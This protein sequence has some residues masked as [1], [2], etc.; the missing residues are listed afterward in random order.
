MTHVPAP[1]FAHTLGP[2]DATLVLVGEAWGSTEDQLK[3]PLVGWSGLELAR[4]LHETGHV[5]EPPP[6][7]MGSSVD[8]LRL[9]K[10]WKDSGILT[11]NVFAFRPPNNN[12]LHESICG[13]KAEVGG[14]DY[15]LPQLKVGKYVR[16]EYLGE[17]SRLYEELAAYPRN[18]IVAMG[19]TATWAL[20][21]DTRIGAIRG[22]I[23]HSRLSEIVS[24]WKILP[25]YHPANVLYQWSNRVILVVDLLKAKRERDFPDVRRPQRWIIVDPTLDEVRQWTARTLSVVKDWKHGL[26]PRCELLSVD[27]ETF[28]GQI[29]SIA[30]A[31]SRSEAL[32]VPFV[33]RRRPG[34]SY[35][36]TQEVEFEVWKNVRALCESNI[37]KLFQNGLFDLTYLYRAGIRPRNCI[38]DSM[39]L[40][41]SLYPEMQ[42]SLAFLGSIYSN[43]AAWKLMRRKKREDY[44]RDE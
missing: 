41:H 2:R 1:A 18:L 13:S 29:E 40:H 12:L 44:K 36:P 6:A 38:E 30:F 3:V 17:L 24:P 4:I 11:T 16:P 43:E 19:A 26:V 15:L 32:C 25:V 20:L 28:Q 37:R 14:K 33:D 39:V 35:W 27:I 21:R 9:I 23:T 34:W 5:A 7:A 8:S 31:T 42:K 22:A 10:W